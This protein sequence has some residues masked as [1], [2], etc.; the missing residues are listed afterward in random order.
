MS[1][2]LAVGRCFRRR[3]RATQ[4]SFGVLR[5]WPFQRG[6]CATHRRIR[7]A[8]DRQEGQERALERCDAKATSTRRCIFRRSNQTDAPIVLVISLDGA[9]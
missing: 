4:P 7:R 6:L 5:K 3:R 2:K 1:D 8:A 9:P